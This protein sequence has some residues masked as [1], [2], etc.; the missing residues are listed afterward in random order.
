MSL[1]RAYRCWAEVDLNALRENLAWI[2]HRVGP[3]TQIMTVVKADAYGHGLKEIASHLMNCGTNAFGVANLHEAY[4]IRSRGQGWPILM[5][6]ACTKDEIEY[7]IRLK[8]MGTVS[9]LDEAEAYV[10]VAK[11]M[12]ATALIQVKVDTGMGRLGVETDEAL[13]LVRQLKN[14]EEQEGCIRLKGVYTHLAAVEDDED[15]TKNQLEQFS[16]LVKQ[17]LSTGIGLD[18]THA[19]S[20]GG[21]L[22]EDNSLFNT[23][24]PGL[25]IYGIAPTGS[26]VPEGKIQDFLRPALSLKCRVSLVKNIPAGKTLSYGH[27]YTSPKPMKVATL[28]AGYGDGYHRA[29][30][31]KGYV[32]IHGQRCPILGRIT[33]DQ[34]IVDVSAVQVSVRNGDVA[35][36]I[37]SQGEESITAAQVA[38]WAGTI[39]WEILTSI[40]YR[41]HRA[42]LGINAS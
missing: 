34:M 26:R 13:A 7:A 29:A 42:Y 6:G 2:R 12:K 11:K 32:L 33:M 27:T 30:S 37:G 38:E 23:T 5:L 22:F 41:V 28:T 9:T 15:F 1:F 20:S 36:L 35:V 39:P 19:S 24:R 4:D 18:Y 21:I 8:V 31:G 14:M 25:I 16:S 40:S 3:L 17:L 10:T